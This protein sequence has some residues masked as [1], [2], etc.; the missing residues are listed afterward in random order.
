M[1]REMTA[2]D[3][4]EAFLVRTATRENVITLETLSSYG[5][6]EASLAEA[7]IFD[8]KGWVSESAGRITGFVMGDKSTGEMQVL[9]ILPDFENK[10]IGSKLLLKVT[11]WL[12]SNGHQQ[13][14]LKT[15]PNQS[16]RA[17]GFYQHFGWM[18]TGKMDSEDEV[19]VLSKRAR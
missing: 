14:W 3:L 11:E 5:I 4:P 13:L 6:T 19:F 8:V 18:P 17:Y 7:M 2:A 12:F 1:I 9:A 16:F 10:G 15:T